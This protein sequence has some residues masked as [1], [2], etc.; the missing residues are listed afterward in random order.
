MKLKYEYLFILLIVGD[1]LVVIYWLGCFGC[2]KFDNIKNLMVVIK[3]FFSLS[4]D[5]LGRWFVNKIIGDFF[6]LL[7]VFVVLKKRYYK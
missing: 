1:K 3:V 5:G 7:I 6:D 2:M 4:L